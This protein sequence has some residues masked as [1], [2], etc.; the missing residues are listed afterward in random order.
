[1]PADSSFDKA[2]DGLEKGFFDSFQNAAN[3]ARRRRIERRANA[4]RYTGG[5]ISGE[6]ETISPLLLLPVIP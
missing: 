1:M 4:S 5:N 3:N 2:W 6:T